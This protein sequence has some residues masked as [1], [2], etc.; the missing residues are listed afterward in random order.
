[1]PAPA[2]LPR[3]GRESAVA[4]LAPANVFVRSAERLVVGFND[5]GLWKCE[6]GV[7]DARLAAATFDR[8]LYL[9]LHRLGCMGREERA[10][11]QRIIRPGMTVLDVGANLGLYTALFARLVG[12]AGAVIAF[13]PDPALF[14]LLRRNATLNGCTNITAHNLA[15][16]S[17]SDRAM[18]RKMIFN[19]GDNTLGSDGNRCFRREVPIDVV[20]LDE[21]LPALHVDVVKIDVQGWEFEVLLGMDRILAACP[22]AGIYF[23]LWPD[24]LRRAGRTPA[25]MAEWLQDRG[26]RLYHAATGSELDEAGFAVLVSKLTG[27][28]HAD[29]LALRR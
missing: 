28:K 12:K 14:A 13:E 20:A 6:C 18:L 4:P 7:W 24:G 11:L 19:S 8:W 23:E 25:E 3:G 2:D 16:G 21:F 26:Y 17:R 1:V 10:A 5:L 22:H 29:L 15:L 9:R 27:M